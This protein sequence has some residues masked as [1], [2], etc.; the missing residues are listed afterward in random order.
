MNK[1]ALDRNKWRR[2]HD[3]FERR[4]LENSP[5]G[6]PFTGFSHQFLVDDELDYKRRIAANAERTLA[7][8]TWQA[9]WSG[10][11]RILERVRETC[12][13]GVS[14]NL[15]GRTSDRYGPQNGPA[16]ALHRDMDRAELAEL[17]RALFAFFR[18]G[19]L[20][21][22]ALGSRF[23][24]LVSYLKLR[25]LGCSWPFLSYLTFVANPRLF[26]PVQPSPIQ[27]LLSYLGDDT[28]IERRI[29][30]D[31]YDHL[32]DVADELRTLLVAFDPADAI[33]I[34]SY[35]YVLGAIVQEG[36][37][38]MVR[39]SGREDRASILQAL[40]ARAA[41]RVR[42]GLDGE[43]FVLAQE[44]ERLR[45][46][47]RSDLAERA[48][49]VSAESDSYGYDV[50]SFAADG[51]ERHIEVKT[52]RATG[53]FD[54][55]I[56]LTENERATALT[57]PAWTLVRVLDIDGSAEAVD[58]GNPVLHAADRWILTPASWTL[59]RDGDA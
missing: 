38:R 7:L 24:D 3:A 46:A 36:V 58:L 29:S 45:R 59:A 16:R 9:A 43:L 49:L 10:S 41:E 8:A 40:Q 51:T 26:F 22:A 31:T 57:D 47:S 23:D 44:R 4:M 18:G 37:P 33:E 6:A 28:K 11:G 42:T 53:S 19:P 32:L 12:A 15:L 13:S 30:W 17:E 39:R 35:M 20:S 25:R 1:V 5:D 56:W 52:T 21:R 27:A 55:P 54:A 2:L 14:K 34:Q 50:L 48:R